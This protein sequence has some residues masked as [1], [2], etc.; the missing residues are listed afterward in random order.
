MVLRLSSEDRKSA[1][2][3]IRKF[4]QVIEHVNEVLPNLRTLQGIFMRHKAMFTGQFSEKFGI[5][6]PFNFTRNSTEEAHK[7]CF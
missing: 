2:E 3:D 4:V 6:A 7:Q 5:F 1:A